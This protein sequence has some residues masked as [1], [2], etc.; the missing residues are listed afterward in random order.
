MSVVL[1]PLVLSSRNVHGR[2]E[3]PVW[4]NP[5]LNR[6][7]QQAREKLVSDQ[8]RRLRS[9]RGVEVETVFGRIKQDW[10]F[11]RFT[12]RGME[13]VKTEW[14]LL[15]IAHNH[16]KTGGPMTASFFCL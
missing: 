7:Q 2:W 1:A 14:G 5:T 3:S 8:G 12:L 4:I 16:S 9:R 13:K 6:Y 15:C 11:R 10:G